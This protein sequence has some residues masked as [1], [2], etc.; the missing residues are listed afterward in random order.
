MKKVLFTAFSA[1]ALLGLTACGETTT[2]DGLNVEDILNK[3]M[4]AMEDLN[5]YSIEMDMN[6]LM[7]MGDEGEMAFDSSGD[8]ELTMEPMTLKQSTRID[9]GEFGM[10]E[11]SEMTYL[12]YFTEDEG[13]F[14]EDPMSGTWLKLPEEVM[15]D[16]LAMSEA[17]LNPEDQLKPFKEH[18]SEVSVETTD[19]SYVITLAGD[20]IDMEQLMEQMGGMG[21]EG[22]DPMLSEMMEDI[23]IEALAYEIFVDKETF[24]QTEANIDMTM[25]MTIMEET[26]TTQQKSN[27]IF[28]DFD[29]IDPIEIPQDVL[30]NAEEVSEEE[31]MGGGF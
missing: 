10:G 4:S 16:M 3:T 20:G 26:M 14:V 21:L 2:E 9:M 8:V 11:E 22:M 15:N 1:A 30:D 6:Q 29:K 28:S 31:M 27:M 5:S 13:F 23:D 18:I 17:Q 24:Y 7:K 12:T 25:T 19:S